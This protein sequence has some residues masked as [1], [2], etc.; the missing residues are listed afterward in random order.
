VEKNVIVSLITILFVG[1]CIGAGCF[2]W[3]RLSVDRSDRERF[4][5]LNATVDELRSSLAERD[6]ND[7][8]VTR[9]LTESTT[10]IR[11]SIDTSKGITNSTEKLRIVV[12]ALENSYNTA[13]RINDI[14]SRNA[15]NGNTDK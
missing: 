8:E 2:L 4:E 15:H 9:I 7:A 10:D 5:K 6:R 14:L 11:Q 3:G 1:V 13:R 12:K